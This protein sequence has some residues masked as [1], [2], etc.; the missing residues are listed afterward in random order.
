MKIWIDT[1]TGIDDVLAIV[2]ALTSPK[3][4][5]VGMSG[6]HGNVDVDNATI[7]ANTIVRLLGKSL[8]VMKGAGLSLLGNSFPYPDCHGV[9]GLADVMT[10]SRYE[11]IASG[12]APNYLADY[13][14]QS[15]DPIRVVALGPLTNIALALSIRPDCFNNGHSL[16][17]M[18]GAMLAQG[19][20][21]ASAEF[22]T[23]CDPEAAYRIVHSGIKQTWIS[24]DVTMKTMM[25]SSWCEKMISSER[26]INQLIGNIT[27]FYSG[28]YQRMYSIDG[29]ALHDPL[30]IGYLLWPDLFKIVPVSLEIELCGKSTRGKTVPD[31]FEGNFSEGKVNALTATE[32]N[33][34]LFIENFI[35]ALDG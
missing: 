16:L 9:D 7:N 11:D 13:L 27:K 12:F 3:L 21:T 14:S 33:T 2:L 19:N 8:P 30:T 4:D 1:D 24:L 20:E 18:G 35:N 25:P 6:V 32:V 26:K 15:P 23:W 29:F 17:I 28:W 31:F 22:N 10:S 34:N 5:V